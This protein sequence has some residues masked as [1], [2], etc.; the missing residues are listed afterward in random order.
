LNLSNN[1]QNIF[2]LTSNNTIIA[3][4]SISN[5]IYGVDIGWFGWLDSNSSVYY[6]FYPFNT[7]VKGNMLVNNGVG[8]R[9]LGSDNS[10]IS[11]NTLHTNPLGIL[12]D[13]SNSTISRNV[14]VASDER[15]FDRA[16]YPGPDLGIFYYPEWQW[17]RSTE[18]MR[19][20][21]GGIIV[22][23]DCTVVY[24]NTVMNSFIG[25]SLMD[26]IRSIWSYR[27]IIF[28]N[29]LI[30]NT[31][32]AMP[33][34]RARSYW[35]N[36]YPSGGNYWSDYDGTDADLDGIGDT[37]YVIDANNLDYYPLIQPHTD[38]L[39]DIN[40]DRKVDM[41]D[42]S[43]VARRFM[44]V[45]EDPLWDPSADLN[46]DG[47]INMIDIGTVAKHFGEHYP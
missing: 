28:H 40:D 32:Q 7:T 8:I 29:N 17:E 9:V 18:L 3:N 23:G 19:Y 20:E 33:A 41:R 5:S 30:N 37:P 27:C 39:G 16:S 35:N 15:S 26:V 12:A 46:G 34:L 43:Y 45:P 10:T 38:I 22:G 11:N 1:V 31:Y 6:C 4:N 44:C 13:T 14:I 47:K 25:I 24:D 21:I 2:L 42:V 36:S